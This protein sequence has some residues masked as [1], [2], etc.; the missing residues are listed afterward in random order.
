M[1]A[2]TKAA[3]FAGC[4]IVLHC[5]GDK[6]EMTDVAK[7]A[8]TLDGISL[9]RADAGARP[10]QHAHRHSIL[11]AAEARLAELLDIRPGEGA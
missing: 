2:R 5:N 11:A 9:K 10:S 3:L 8:K 6:D 1:A 7:E 4:D